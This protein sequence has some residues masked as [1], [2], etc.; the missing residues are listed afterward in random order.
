MKFPIRGES[1]GVGNKKL[2]FG[3]RLPLGVPTTTRM[4]SPHWL[5]GTAESAEA[6]QVIGWE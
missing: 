1:E 4:L 3:A 6:D 5:D 2:F